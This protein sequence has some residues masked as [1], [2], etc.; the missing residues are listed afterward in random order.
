MYVGPSLHRMGLCHYVNLLSCMHHPYLVC[1]L[2]GMSSLHLLF[3]V[4]IEVREC[5]Q[6]P[7][8]QLFIRFCMYTDLGI[9]N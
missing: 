2:F 5:I 1:I 4:Q 3:L 6:S 7:T 9:V 8:I